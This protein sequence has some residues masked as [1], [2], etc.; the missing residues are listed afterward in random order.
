MCSRLALVLVLAMPLLVGCSPSAKLIGT[1]DLESE[2]LDKAAASGLG[3][4]IPPALAGFMKPKLN[5]EFVQ[6]GE[7]VVEAK[8]AGETAKARGKWRYVKSEGDVLVLKVK[9]DKLDEQE[10]RVRFIDNNKIETVI[11]PVGEDE[12]WTDQTATFARRPY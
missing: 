3:T 2:E 1:W 11:F 4:R 8:M 12:S 7:Y 10:V 5:I 9:M 6:G